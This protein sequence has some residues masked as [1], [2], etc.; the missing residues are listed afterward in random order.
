[1]FPLARISAVLS[2]LLLIVM[3][4]LA[5]SAQ[6]DNPTEASPLRLSYV[7]GDVS[8][9]R[10]GAED[11]VEARHNTP[12]ASGDALYVGRDGDLELQMGSRAFIRA[13]DDTQLTLVNQTADFIQFKITSGRVSFDLRTLPS[14]YSVEVDTPNAVFTIDRSG[15]YRVDV[16]GDVHFITRRGGRAMMVPAGGQAMSIQP[17]EEI[18]VRNGA[19]ARAETYVAPEPDRWDRWNYARTDDLVDAVSER[20]LP[21]GIAGANDLDHYGRWRVVGDYGPVW[22]PDAVPSGWAP[23]S[24]GRWV[25]DPNYQWTWIDDAPWGWAPYHYGRWVYLNS[26]WAWAPGPAV[27]V[28]VYAPALVAFFGVG[29]NVSVGIGI[30]TA[31]LG[32]VALSWGEPLVPWWG[33]PGFVGR[34]WWGGWHGP[35]VVNNVVIKQTTVV[36]VTNITY[37]NTRVH[38]AVV[39]TTHERFG[40]GQM[41][42]APVR[43]METRQLRH[44]HGALPVKPGPASVMTGAPSRIRPP[45][46]VLS[47]AVVS[48]RPARESTL[49]WRNEE[50]RRQGSVEPEPRYVP[51]PVRQSSELPRPAFGAQTGEERARPP[52]PPRFEERRREA[53]APGG[54]ARERA[55]RGQVEQSSPPAAISDNPEAATPRR[56]EPRMVPEPARRQERIERERTESSG[57]A[58]APAPFNRAQERAASGRVEPV[59]PR[60]VSP[61]EMMP[62]RGMREPAPTRPGQER[63]RERERMMPEPRRLDAAP[64]QPRAAPEPV[65]RQERVERIERERADLPGQPANRTF[66]GQDR[67]DG[68]RRRSQQ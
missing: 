24:T 22:V 60:M 49:P 64:A 55:E 27:R 8:F 13:D 50:R 63:E 66:R 34:P 16:N 56:F 53:E 11:W 1:M 61:E 10:D 51:A 32:W 40:R 29:S 65:R 37:R 23:Y 58:E 39:A 25:W 68:E 18:V 30:G 21:P 14:G 6:D 3:S 48:T 45:E 17:S 28:A 5:V 38:N 35:R 57:Q 15:Y 62:P 19:V 52:L 36:N 12:L 26:Y 31:G 20:Y 41:H 4:S 43:V 9:F 44:M 7:E 67:G 33:R 42:D 47:R 54:R 59:A 2:L 46:Q